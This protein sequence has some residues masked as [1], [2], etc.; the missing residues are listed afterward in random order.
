MKIRVTLKAV[1]A[2]GM[3][4]Q[5]LTK[6][7]YD[8][9][10]PCIFTAMPIPTMMLRPG[11]FAYE[12]RMVLA[13][14]NIRPIMIEGFE[15]SS[16]S[17]QIKASLLHATKTSE[18]LTA[19]ADIAKA[20]DEAK[21]AAHATDAASVSSLISRIEVIL[22]MINNE[23]LL[24]EIEADAAEVARYD[25]VEESGVPMDDAQ[26]PGA[27]PVDDDMGAEELDLEQVL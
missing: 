17:T 27:A 21:A 16:V 25:S 5:I 11:M 24:D 6:M 4:G 9:V 14:Y 8:R 23:G 7:G 15:S 10:A 1:D 12:T 3:G 22:S 2:D 13:N 20:A 18:L 19:L 26:F